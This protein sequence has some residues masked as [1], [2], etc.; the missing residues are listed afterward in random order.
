MSAGRQDNSPH[1]P[2]SSVLEPQQLL[3]IKARTGV[4]VKHWNRKRTRTWACAALW[5]L[6]PE[7]GDLLILK[8][9]GVRGSTNS[10]A[11]LIH[12]GAQG[13]DA[14][15]YVK[16]SRNYGDSKDAINTRGIT[17]SVRWEAGWF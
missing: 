2:S 17:W 1:S 5:P 16:Q 10:L 13:A 15:H 4:K 8:M 6:L 14:T 11:D 9:P 3:R 12:P 7:D